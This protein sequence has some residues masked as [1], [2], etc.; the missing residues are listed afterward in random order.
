MEL[1]TWF[2]FVTLP[3]TVMQGPAAALRCS[4]FMRR[5]TGWQSK[6]MNNSIGQ[7]T[8]DCALRNV[9]F[10]LYRNDL[11]SGT[12]AI[13]LNSRELCFLYTSEASP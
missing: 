8:L 7:F 6:L 4:R 12:L 3:M 9:I 1:E 11:T 13:Q 5:V 2:I 10:F